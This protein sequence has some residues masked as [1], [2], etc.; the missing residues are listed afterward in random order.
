MLLLAYFFSDMLYIGASTVYGAMAEVIFG[1]SVVETE[2]NKVR[3]PLVEAGYA[4]DQKE[5]GRLQWV[6]A[7]CMLINRHPF[8]QTFSAQLIVTVHDLLADIAGTGQMTGR[9]ALLRLQTSLCHLG[10]LDE[11][12]ILDRSHEKT[13]SGPAIWQNDTS[14]DPLWCAWVRADLAI[15]PRMGM[16]FRVVKP[17]TFSWWPADGSTSTTQR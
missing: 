2:V 12:A 15:R 3:T 7:L 13:A 14:L 10:M 1:R 6:T 5:G 16:R 11:P 8:V 9:W 17:V 4:A